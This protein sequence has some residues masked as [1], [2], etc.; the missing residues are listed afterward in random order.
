[1]VDPSFKKM[2]RSRWK[3]V[4]SKLESMPQ[5]IDQRAKKISYSQ[6][7]NFKRWDVLGMNINQS[8]FV[9]ATH[10]EYVG[11]VRDFLTKRIT[12]LDGVINGP[13]FD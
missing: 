5:Y 3:E 11:F 2:V 13:Q 1:M 10:Q 7:Y 6:K 9:A 8:W 4:K 12:W